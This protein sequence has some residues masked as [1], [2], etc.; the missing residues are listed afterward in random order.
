MKKGILVVLGVILPLLGFAQVPVSDLDWD[1]GARLGVTVDK[2]LMKGLH[3]VADGQ[4]R[5]VDNFA[6]VGR[7]D[8]GL[9]ISYKI[10]RMFKVGG[11]YQF[12]YKTNTAGEWIPRH[13]FY[14]D[15]TASVH[16]GYW[17]IALKEKFQLTHRE[18][19][20]TYENN[21]NNLTLKSRLKV[22]YKGLEH[23]TPY[24]YVEVR[25]V[26]NDPTCSATWNS[27]S[28]T[29]SDY[30]FTGY[31]AAYVN[32]VRGVIG[33]EWKIDRNNA[34]DFYLLGEYTYDKCLDVDKDGP[35]LKSIYYSQHI[36]CA[37]CVGYVFSF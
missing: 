13:R 16:F 26:F 22:S 25:N 3:L 32:R 4:V 20:N 27:A 23:W 24:A 36:H 10:N 9:G 7:W 5:M 15:G 31:N 29:Y 37:L 33:T 1:C 17:H 28:G 8:A 18:F 35:T 19:K 11:G 30:S 2:K 34:L 12:I 6:S 14:V 21:P